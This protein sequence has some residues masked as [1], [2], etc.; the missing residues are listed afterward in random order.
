[1][2]ESD[3]GWLPET[4]HYASGSL[5]I[6]P[7]ESAE[8]VIQSIRE[9]PRSDG[10]WL[11][12]PLIEEGLGAPP[13]MQR[14]LVYAPSFQ[15]DPTHVIRTNIPNES[16][17]YLHFQIQVLG[18]A[19]GL[20]L[21]P[22]GWTH[23]Y[24]LCLRPGGLT[25]LVC[26]PPDVETILAGAEAFWLSHPAGRTRRLMFGAIH[27]HL[28][29]QSYLHEFEIFNAEYT[30]LDTCFRI[31]CEIAGTAATPSHSRRPSF[32]CEQYGIPIPPWAA[33]TSTGSCRLAD[34]RNELVHEA[35]YAGQSIGFAYP[36]D[37][38]SLDVQLACLNTRLLI[39]LLG[40]RTSYVTSRVD[41]RGKCSFAL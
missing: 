38:Y 12:P 3:F 10:K 36:P 6:S 31:H 13:S 41:T 14:P 7:L 25:D 20:R 26:T 21:V 34:L 28:F 17:P 33:V 4:R 1:M 19:Q 30:V 37:A 29:A 40:F 39:A 9:H 15:V 8:H 2:L 23:F 35:Q 24:R 11:H 18:L 5:Q 27:W 16:R 22:R 32:L